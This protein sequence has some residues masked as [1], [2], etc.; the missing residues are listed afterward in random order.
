MVSGAYQPGNGSLSFTLELSLLSRPFIT[1][2]TVS[3]LLSLSIFPHILPNLTFTYPHRAE[4]IS[5]RNFTSTLSSL[6]IQIAFK[7][8]LC[9]SRLTEER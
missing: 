3:N 8:S 6:R 5:L 2:R 7:M 9:Q 4:T 1:F